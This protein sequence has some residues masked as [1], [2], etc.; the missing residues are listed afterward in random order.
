MFLATFF[1]TRWLTM[2]RLTQDT[3]IARLLSG[4]IGR[5][6]EQFGITLESNLLSFNFLHHADPKDLT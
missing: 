3:A 4:L 2:L 1:S 6:L 5:V